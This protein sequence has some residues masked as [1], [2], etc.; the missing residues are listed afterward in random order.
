M[1]V[2]LSSLD[3]KL[4]LNSRFPGTHATKFKNPI[5]TCSILPP[6]PNV[7]TFETFNQAYEP[8]RDWL[9]TLHR[10]RPHIDLHSE[11]DLNKREPATSQ[12]T[13]HDD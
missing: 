1:S 5:F 2:Q 7:S 6:P 8:C 10:R 3:S 13:K 9:P 11:E 12:S 4:N